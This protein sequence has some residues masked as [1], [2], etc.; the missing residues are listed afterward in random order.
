VGLIIFKIE[1]YFEARK[2]KAGRFYRDSIPN[3]MNAIFNHYLNRLKFSPYSTTN[4]ARKTILKIQQILL[5]GIQR[6]YRTQGVSI[7]DKHIEIIVRQMTSKVRILN[8]GLTSFLPGELIDVQI[9]LQLNRYLEEEIHF[10]P[11]VLGITQASL[12]VDS[13]ISSSSFQQTTR[14]LS[15]AA[16][17]KKRDYL[18]GL[19]ENVILGNLMPSGTGHAIQQI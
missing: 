2:S 5:N 6:V 7:A 1:Q 11:I 12:E 14:V 19:K 13:F 17:D 18:R 8:P 16:L 4:A 9:I 15:E 10:E 3:L